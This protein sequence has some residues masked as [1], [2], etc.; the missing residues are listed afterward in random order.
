MTRVLAVDDEPGILSVVVANLRARGYEV[1]SAGTG[2]LALD[3]AADRTPDAV[4][5]DLGLPGM[6]GYEVIQALRGWTDIPI[7][8]LS[9]RETTQDKVA[10]LEAGAD[11]YMTKPFAID[12]LLAR[13]QALVRRA[14][15]A[16]NVIE[17]ADF[18]LDFRNRRATTSRGPVHLTRTEWRL[19]E[20]F[21]RNPG[22]LLAAD[23][24]YDA[25]W[26]TRGKKHSSVLRI[27][28]GHLRAKLEPAPTQPRYFVT[29]LGGGYRFVASRPDTDA[30]GV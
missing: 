17:T 5:L 15:D 7:I 25:A 13:V 12:E 11:D 24:L 27:H 26:G 20:V 9:A 1:D 16:G 14:S 28:I 4:I 21:A 10:A 2:E 6:S 30:D 19:A 22:R 18:T 8:V 23:E 3:V 29:E